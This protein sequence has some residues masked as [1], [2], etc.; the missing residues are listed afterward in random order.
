MCTLTYI[1]CVYLNICT[2]H[3]YLSIHTLCVYLN[4]CT[5]CVYLNVCTLCVYLNVCILCVYLNVCTLCMYL[6]VCTL[7]VYLNQYHTYVCLYMYIR[8]CAPHLLVCLL[9]TP[10]TPTATLYNSCT[11]L[12]MYVGR[13][14]SHNSG[15]VRTVCVLAVHS[16]SPQIRTDLLKLS[17]TTVSP[18]VPLPYLF[19][20][21][22]CSQLCRYM[23]S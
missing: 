14:D 2:L 21:F 17:L 23:A 13:A 19:T 10:T 7:C 15:C 18:T 20:T 1:H 22:L 9:S 12:C 11:Y 5:M 3:V 4:I 6:N 16:L 8:T